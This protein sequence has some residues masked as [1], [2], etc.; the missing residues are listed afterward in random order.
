[1]WPWGHL[2]CGYLL[3]TAV[4]R[5]Y[6]DRSPSGLEIVVLALGTQFPDLIDK[7][8]AWSVSVLPNGR[9]LTHSVLVAAVIVVFVALVCRR[10]RRQPVAVAF[11]VGYASHLAGDAIPVFFRGTVSELA[12]L[13]WP[14]LPPVE[15]GA[16]KSFA[17]HLLGLDPSPFFFFEIALSAV[18]L[19]VWVRDGMPGMTELR[20]FL[21]RRERSA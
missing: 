20:S 7:P 15:Y 9:S 6:G 21:A 14:V 13:L 5:R 2:A 3:Y 8:L 16:P 18:A 19:G 12:F 10:L 17:A 4:S 1:M 11:A